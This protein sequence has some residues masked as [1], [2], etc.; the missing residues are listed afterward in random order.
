[1]SAKSGIYLMLALIT[2]VVAAWLLLF[3]RYTYEDYS[4]DCQAEGGEFKVEMI[5][6]FNKADPKTKGAPFYL[7]LVPRARVEYEVLDAQLTSDQTQ[8]VSIDGLRSITS[9]AAGSSGETSWLAENL[10]IPYRDYDLTVR[11]K[12]PDD[13]AVSVMTCKLRTTPKHEWRSPW[14]D[15]IMS[16]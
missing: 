3:D 14:W 12:A 7:K 15:A 1:M 9:N 5:G 6:A 11:Y 16:V 4:A 8:V 13:P 2:A 10:D